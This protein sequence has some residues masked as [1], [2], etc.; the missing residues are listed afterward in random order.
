MHYPEITT[1]KFWLCFSPNLLFCIFTYTVF[2]CMSRFPTTLSSVSEVP[3]SKFWLAVVQLGAW[4]SDL[5]TSGLFLRGINNK[6]VRVGSVNIILLAHLNFWTKKILPE[7]KEMFFPSFLLSFF[8][9]DHEV[10][11][12]EK[13][14]GLCILFCAP[15]W[16]LF[17]CSIGIILVYTSSNSRKYFWIPS[18]RWED[19]GSENSSRLLIFT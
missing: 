9:L 6:N 11:K 17:W 1:R 14:M 16:I 10:R 12:R 15:C 19:W 4:P 13:R 7:G 2:L 18:Y 5:E 3:F 8:Q